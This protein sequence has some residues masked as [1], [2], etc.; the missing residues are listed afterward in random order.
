MTGGVCGRGACMAEG[1]CMAGEA[2]MT[3]SMHA[4]G[5]AWWGRRA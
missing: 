4:R 2:C 5:H 3:G 1:L